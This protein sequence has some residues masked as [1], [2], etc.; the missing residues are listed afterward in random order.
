MITEKTQG[1]PFFMEEMV[2][3]LFEEGTLARNGEIKLTRPLSGI[4]IPTTVQ[5]MLAARIDRLPADEK[6]LLQ[7][8]TVIGREFPL[9]LVACLLSISDDELNRMLSDLQLGEFIYEQPAAGGIEYIFKHALT[10]EVSYNSILVERR[11]HI[12]ERVAQ[13]VESLFAAS[14]ADHYTELA[15]HYG[16]SGNAS[17]AVNY[18][19][20]AGQQAMNRS[21]YVEASGQLTSALELLRIQPDDL[22]R[23]RTEV[24]MRFSLAV[25]VNLSV[26]GAIMKTAAVEN[27]ERARDLCE[28]IGD[29]TGRLEILAALANLYSGRLEGQK[30]TRAFCR[31]LLSIATRL[32]DS[33]RIGHAWFWSG[34][35]SL[36]QGNLAAALEEFDEAYK[37]PTSGSPK[38]EVSYGNWRT[39]CRSLASLALWV[40]GYPERAADRNREALVVSREIVASPSDT[41]ATLIWSALLNLFLRDPETAY[42]RANEARRLAHEH[43]I[44]ALIPFI[45]G[46]CRSRSL[47]QMG[48]IE[49]GLSEMLRWQTVVRQIAAINVVIAAMFFAIVEV[50][51][52]AGHRLEG[53]EAVNEGLEIARRTGI[54]FGEAELHRLKGELL[55]LGDS[56]AASG[57]SGAA[58]EAARCFHDAIEVARRQSA[59]SWELRATTSLARLLDQQGRRDAARAMLADIY[60]WFTEGFDTADLKDAKALLDELGA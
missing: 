46:L 27:L 29:D 12:H 20:L 51:L 41:T 31:E 37:L 6:D 11:K 38:W 32:H 48:Q 35:S 4:R 43:G 50:D 7:T 33:E 3:N 36:W 22:E 56:S 15:H 45:D 54:G 18:L 26:P 24:A 19:H 42:A 59:K 39:L 47:A 40:L 49:E 57:D 21:A 5:A 9:V 53:L 23:D 2:Q 30:E 16:R 17:K 52:I 1:N 60:D 34:F 8:L 58:S 44:D 28:K 13:A 14:L 55:L 25:C 10:Q